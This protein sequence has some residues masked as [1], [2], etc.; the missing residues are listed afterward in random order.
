M[1]KK[2]KLT[3]AQ[4]MKIVA[5]EPHFSHVEIGEQLHIDRST[6]TKFIE[7]YKNRNSIENLSR[8]GRPRK[9]SKSEN[10]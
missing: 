2:H 3:D 6:I 9:I 5:L 1:P 10:R 7:C 4:K 8:P